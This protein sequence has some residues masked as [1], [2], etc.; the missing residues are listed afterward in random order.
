MLQ[1]ED[2]KGLVDQ[3]VVKLNGVSALSKTGEKGKVKRSVRYNPGIPAQ[4]LYA[5][6]NQAKRLRA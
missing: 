2:L 6:D 1:A 5:L 4:L 3:K